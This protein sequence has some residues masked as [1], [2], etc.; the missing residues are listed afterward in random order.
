MHRLVYVSWSF[1]IVMT[2]HFCNICGQIDFQNN[3]I[4][5]H[6]ERQMRRLDYV[7]WSFDQKFKIMTCSKFQENQSGFQ[8]M[9][10]HTYIHTCGQRDEWTEKCMYMQAGSLR[11]NVRPLLTASLKI[12]D[13]EVFNLHTSGQTNSLPRKNVEKNLKNK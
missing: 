10:I 3:S 1:D 5:Q 7:S 4:Y 12:S 11:R 6:M 8:V 2:L 13:Q 9:T